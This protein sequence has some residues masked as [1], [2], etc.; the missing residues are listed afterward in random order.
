[1]K[2]LPTL[3]ASAALIAAGSGIANAG[4]FESSDV[5][6]GFTE[7]K[8]GVVGDYNAHWETVNELL[9]QDKIHITL[10]K[11]SDYATPNR[12]LNDGEIDL[13][14]FQH[15]AYLNNDVAKNGYDITP[16][17]QTFICPLRIYNNKDRIQSVEDIKDGDVI[18]IP[19]DL[20][21]GGRAIKLL[22]AAG[23]LEVDPSKG[24]VPTKADITNYKVKIELREAESGVLFNILPD[25]AAA[26][27]NG[28][29]AFSAGLKPADAIFNETV[30]SNNPY[31]N[32]IVARTADKDNPVY[33]T[34]VKRFLTKEVHDSILKAYD[35]GYIPVF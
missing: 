31:I 8:V 3:L 5:P 27:I 33:Q 30:D 14:A 18:A 16:L 29:N 25:V 35:G 2:F 24:Y 17:C 1:M 13:D 11:Y 23:F 9:Q 19:S 22:E 26:C 32:V 28:G 21:N 4:W 34:V 6:E 20:T 10:V 7:V 12:A 15:E